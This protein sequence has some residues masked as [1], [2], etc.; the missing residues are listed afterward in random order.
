MDTSDSYTR[1]G[2]NYACFKS[3]TIANAIRLDQTIVH[4]REIKN[5]I[6]ARSSI[7]NHCLSSGKSIVRVGEMAQRTSVGPTYLSIPHELMTAGWARP[8]KRKEVPLSRARR[9]Y[10]RAAN[11]PLGHVVIPEYTKK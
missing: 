2:I 10:P 4:R 7:D 8:E 6:A 3:P 1:T 11:W 9:R 5:T